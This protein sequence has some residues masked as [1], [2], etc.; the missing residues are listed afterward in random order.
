VSY[1]SNQG[2]KTID[3]SKKF[4][5]KHKIVV[6]TFLIENKRNIEE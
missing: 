2:Y 1:H 4:D 5:F 6:T 3:D